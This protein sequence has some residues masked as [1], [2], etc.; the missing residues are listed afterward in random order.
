MLTLYPLL[1]L[2]T[3]KNKDVPTNMNTK[4]ELIVLPPMLKTVS[5][6]LKVVPMEILPEEYGKLT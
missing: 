5:K 1:M 2:N 3:L 6:T 4:L